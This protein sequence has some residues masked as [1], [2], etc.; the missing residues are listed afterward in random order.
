MKPDET[1]PA[2]AQPETPPKPADATQIPVQNNPSSTPL[3]G[4]PTV[5]GSATPSDSPTSNAATPGLPPTKNNRK[6][7][8][9]GLA[10]GGLVLLLVLG[11]VF[12]Y[13]LPNRP[14]AVYRTGMERS[15]EAV[16]KLIADATT[17]QKLQQIKKSE[18]S[19]SLD[20]TFGQEKFSGTFNVKLDPTKTKGNFEVSANENGQ[21]QK[22]GADFMTELKQDARFPDLFFRVNGIKAFGADSLVPGIADYDNKWIAVEAIYLEKL[23][24]GFSATEPKNRENVSS[25]E[26]TQ[27]IKAVSDVSNDYVFTTDSS[28][29][30]LENREF[31]GK[32]KTAEGIEAYRYKVGVNKDH[33]ADYCKAI[34]QR[35]L[36]EP[37]TRKIFSLSQAEIDTAKKGVDKDCDDFAKDIKADKTF[38]MWIDAKYKVIHKVRT[39]EEKDG[40][41]YVDV[42]QIYTGGDKLALFV[43]YN[44]DDDKTNVKL[45]IDVDVPGASS[46]G[47]LIGK[48]SGYDVKADLSAQPY[49]GEIDVTKPAGAIPIEEILKKFG[50]DP[51]ALSNVEPDAGEA[52][53]DT[54]EAN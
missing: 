4:V 8:F 32:E 48:G 51:T 24:A 12:G 23:T 17:E 6:K 14:A 39:F 42:G 16:E 46:K 29:A 20:A 26:I 28:K 45:T 40:K 31:V 22:L 19:G 50:F 54:I 53:L 7:L 13:Y 11:T 5:F 37:A 21:D 15:G 35:V 10:G 27:L 30:V 33:A 49:N 41:A 2:P 9:M 43:T 18:M 47:K 3:G 38:D 25:Q 34:A 36:A 52:E 1:K 44:D